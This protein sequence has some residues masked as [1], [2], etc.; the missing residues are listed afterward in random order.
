MKPGVNSCPGDGAE[1]ARCSLTAQSAACE[2][3][4]RT[5]LLCLPESD[6][7][8]GGTPTTLAMRCHFRL[9]NRNVCW[10]K[11]TEMEVKGHG[12]CCPEHSGSPS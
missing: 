5:G 12:R 6:V 1:S 10:S 3:E 11:E 9:C 8:L 4:G 2:A 7:G